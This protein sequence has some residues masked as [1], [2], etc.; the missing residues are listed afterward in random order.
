MRNGLSSKCEFST[1]CALKVPWDR[2]EDHDV[3][4]RLS[5][6]PRRIIHQLVTCVPLEAIVLGGTKLQRGTVWC[7]VVG[8]PSRYGLRGSCSTPHAH[9]AM[10]RLP[11]WVFLVR[12][13]SQEQITAMHIFE[14]THWH[15]L[16]SWFTFPNFSGNIYGCNA[17]TLRI[18]DIVPTGRWVIVQL[19]V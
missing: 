4:W 11:F 8:A 9:P 1:W 18:F 13:I 16:S 17:G 5:G 19:F 12:C 15:R 3:W 14:V 7:C 10:F 6:K 2:R